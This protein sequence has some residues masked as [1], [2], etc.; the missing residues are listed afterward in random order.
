MRWKKYICLTGIVLGLVGNMILPLKAEEPA[1]EPENLYARSAVL[2]D[3]DSGRVLFGKE[4][5]VVRP[6]ASTTK[7]MTCIQGTA[8]STG[9][10]RVLPGRPAVCADA[11][12]L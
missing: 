3:A 10:R 6:M 12:I 4:A 2:M 5:R 9:G 11:G 1:E 8:W 7:I